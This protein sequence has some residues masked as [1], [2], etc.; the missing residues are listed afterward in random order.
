MFP[1]WIDLP[2]LSLT[3][4]VAGLAGVFTLLNLLLGRPA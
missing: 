2:G 1:F 3:E 4:L